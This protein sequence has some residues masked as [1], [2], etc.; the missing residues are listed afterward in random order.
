MAIGRI[1]DVINGEHHGAHAPGFP[2]AVVYTNPNTLGEV[3]VP[4]HLAVGY[5]MVMDLVI[6]VG[7]VWLARGVV[8]DSG[9]RWRFNWQPRFARAGMLFWFYLFVYS[10]GRFVIQF[11]RQDTP[12]ALGLSQAQLLSVLTAMVAVWALV[13]QVN[14][15]R[16]LGPSRHANFPVAPAIV[17][18]EPEADVAE[19]APLPS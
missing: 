10:L 13:Y 17:G 12:F 7:L 8:R 18:T 16:K 4:V 11:Y 19:H 9:G 6:F 5:E 3:G 14:R 2:L 1:G 15:T